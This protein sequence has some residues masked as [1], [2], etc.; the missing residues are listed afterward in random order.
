MA[1][2]Q[3]PDHVFEFL[4]NDP[5][6]NVEEDPEEEQDMDVKEDIPPLV[7]PHLLLTGQY[8]VKTLTRGMETRRT[9][10]T[11]AMTGVDW[12]RRR[13]DAFD[14]D[15]AFIEQATVK[16]EDDVVALQDRAKTAEARLL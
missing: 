6:L 3:S 1:E 12:V 14:V 16:V 5:T 15:I 2:L 4:G 9:E 10:I 7:A 13:I 11:I 8:S